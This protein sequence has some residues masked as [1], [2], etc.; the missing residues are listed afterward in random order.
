MSTGGGNEFRS[1][2]LVP[3]FIHTTYHN[4]DFRAHI[5]E[6]LTRR[7][8]VISGTPPQKEPGV[9]SQT[10]NSSTLEVPEFLLATAEILPPQVIRTEKGENDEEECSDLFKELYDSLYKK[11]QKV[12]LA[13]HDRCRDLVWGPKDT[14]ATHV[15][16]IPD[17]REGDGPVGPC[18][19][20][21]AEIGE[22]LQNFPD[23]MGDDDEM[24]S[25]KITRKAGKTSF[26][27][28]IREE[29]V[30]KYHR[31]QWESVWHVATRRA[32]RV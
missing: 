14:T 19:F 3:M 4:C 27:P 28:T 8:G 11:A 15:M 6:W 7:N 32:D 30:K 5:Q 24:H 17:P 29:F 23:L 20:D 21:Y 16:G 22:F 13:S 25:V 2:A 18:T 1:H 26:Q 9:A 31:R 12:R 10:Q